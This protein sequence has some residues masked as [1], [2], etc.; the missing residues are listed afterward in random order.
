MTNSSSDGL[1]GGARITVKWI[2]Q[3]PGPIVNGQVT[4]IEPDNEVIGAIN[5]L[6]AHP[7]DSD[8]LYIG[9]VNGGIWRT[10]NA[11]A[12]RPNWEPLTD[13]LPG[14]SIGAIE[15]DPTDL[16]NQTIIVGI[17]RYS[18]F[19]NF[20]GPQ[21]GLLQTT[22]GGNSFTQITDPL[23]T[24]QRITGV[25]QRKNLILASANGGLFRSTDNGRTW[26][27]VSRNNGL[28]SG[29][30]LDL[31]GDRNNLERF[32]VAVRDR[33][34]FS[35]DD[36]GL[37]WVNISANDQTDD[38]LNV[39]IT[40]S[41]G[42]TTEMSIASNG[43]L[44]VGVL[45][46][47]FSSELLY[48]GFSDDQGN[49][50][51]PMDIP[52]IIGRGS[53]NHYSFQSDPN[54]PNIV[55]IG[56]INPPFRGDTTAS[57]GSQWVNLGGFSNTANGSQ[58]HVDSRD[59]VVDANGDLIEVDDGGIY[60]RT[61]PQDNTGDW[62]SVNGDLQVTEL[63]DIAYDTVSNIIIGGTQ[64]NGTA[65]QDE[66][67]SVLWNTVSGADGG[68]V[69][70][71]T[72]SQPG[73]S[74]RYSSFQNLRGFRRRTYDTSGNLVNQDFPALNE[75]D[76]TDF[77]GNFV[78]PVVLNEEDPTRLV[79]GGSNGVYESFDQGENITQIGPGIRSGTQN[80]V[81]YG[82]RSS[83]TPNLDVVYYGSGNNLF[84]RTRAEEM[85]FCSDA[86]GM[87]YCEATTV[88]MFFLMV[89]L[90]RTYS[91]GVREM[92]ACLV[93]LMLTNFC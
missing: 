75:T 45:G 36:N 53:F 35:S 90:E 23:L 31:V 40:E 16:T 22:D 73:F 24:G 37:N 85:I 67:G 18:S 17:G 57:A 76:G 74:I 8:I 68:D 58:P 47:G 33:G 79:L 64:D 15:F 86:L 14:Q 91:T 87:T 26:L 66:T 6:L 50:W 27:L 43:R 41:G 11:T 44:Y 10:T 38:G 61:S 63:H 81:V 54:E 51:K 82:G 92:I 62:F 71:D 25:A 52:P 30:V 34:I 19:A 72:I 55:Y 9:A 93:V 3:G 56:G 80:A 70:V 7:T 42:E 4:N 65:Q 59:I 12:L 20:G 13:N 78:T 2:A 48:V 29:E 39:A 49:T 88:M 77:R 5:T 1:L 84:L 60:R 69:A 83:G 32:Y 46:P 21:T 89:A 28:P